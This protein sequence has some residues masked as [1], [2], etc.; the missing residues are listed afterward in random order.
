MILNISAHQHI[1]K[2][3]PSVKNFNGLKTKQAITG[4]GKAK[5]GSPPE[6]SI[7]NPKNRAYIKESNVILRN[8]LRCDNFFGA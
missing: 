7:P 6:P 2:K 1:K 8:G 5:P 4:A 3:S